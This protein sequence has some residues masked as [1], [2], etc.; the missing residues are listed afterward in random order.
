MGSNVDISEMVN[1]EDALDNININ[2]PVEPAGPA[3]GGQASKKHSKIAMVRQL[4]DR[5]DP[6]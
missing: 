4:H 3:S 1:S 5:Q 2:N 6:Y